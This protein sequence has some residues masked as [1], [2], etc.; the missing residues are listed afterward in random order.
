MNKVIILA[1]LGA[2]SVD[3]V[4]SIALEKAA[5]VKQAPQ[6]LAHFIS[7][8]NL[9][10][11]GKTAKAD[12]KAPKADD[13]ADDKAKDGDGGDKKKVADD[14]A[15][16]DGDTKDSKAKD[17]DDKASE[18]AAGKTATKK[19]VPTVEDSGPKPELKQAQEDAKKE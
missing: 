10:D 17:S 16:K 5:Q 6:S 13:K 2:L 19:P 7:L 3:Q 11:D 18:K 4:Q 15:K 9:K 8:T 1:L 12:D 14:K